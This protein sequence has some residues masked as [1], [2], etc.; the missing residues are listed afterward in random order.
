VSD[1]H[2]ASSF[3]NVFR[4]MVVR[5]LTLAWFCWS[6]AA[7]PTDG[8]FSTTFGSACLPLDVRSLLKSELRE[9]VTLKVRSTL[10]S[11]TH[12]YLFRDASHACHIM[13]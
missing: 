9:A 13:Q 5:T 11:P 3:A 1:A 4:C 12:A 10:R 7:S 6:A 8:I 2:G